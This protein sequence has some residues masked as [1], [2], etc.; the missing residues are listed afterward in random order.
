[1]WILAPLFFETYS[2][3]NYK[4][5]IWKI[6][7]WRNPQKLPFLAIFLLITSKSRTQVYINFYSD[8]LPLWH[9]TI[10]YDFAESWLKIVDDNFLDL[11]GFALGTTMFEITRWYFR[12]SAESCKRKTIYVITSMYAPCLFFRV[13]PKL[14][15][16]FLWKTCLKWNLKFLF[17]GCFITRD[18][19][20]RFFF[21]V[22]SSL[23][24]FS[25]FSFENL[26]IKYSWPPNKSKN[27]TNIFI[28]LWRKRSWMWMRRSLSYMIDELNAIMRSRVN[29]FLFDIS[30]FFFF[31]C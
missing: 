13:R 29:V 7:I 3:I 15:E 19:T 5:I 2:S 14:S 17:R 16:N 12:N 26:I 21:V 11:V 6:N 20:N 8:A 1:M 25:H 27:S 9:L 18:E 22:C 23:Y 4:T 28:W 10:P 31:F 24:L 30:F